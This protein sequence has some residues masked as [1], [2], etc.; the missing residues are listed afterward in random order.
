MG[1]NY[2]RRG[3]KIMSVAI[4]KK[5][6]KRTKVSEDRNKMSDNLKKKSPKTK[7]KKK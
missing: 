6:G 4:E 5:K 1:W 2:N 7:G 3:E